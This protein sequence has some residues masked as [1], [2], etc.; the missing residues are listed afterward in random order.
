M[1]EKKT[2]IDQIE[3]TQSGRIQIRFA[4]LLV[5][6]DE[7]L[8]S[9][10]H[11]AALDVGDD[12]DAYMGIVN[13]HLAS[14]GKVPADAASIDRIKAVCAATWTE[15]VV[16]TASAELTAQMLRVSDARELLAA[17]ARDFETER[18]AFKTEIATYQAERAAF[19]KEFNNH[20]AD[21]QE[22]Q[23]I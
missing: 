1:I 9:K 2:L 13:A 7:I 18:A 12:V 5:D 23:K 15:E 6:G 21:R 4:L 17:A 19:D 3:L 16:A 11:R 22:K 10:W 20:M 8:D 14:M